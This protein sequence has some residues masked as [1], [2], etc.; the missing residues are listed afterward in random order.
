MN[1]LYICIFVLLEVYLQSRVL[2]VGL[3]GQKVGVYA[4]LLGIAKF[5]FR[6]VDQ[7]SFPL[8]VCKSASFSP[9][10]RSRMCPHACLLFL[11]I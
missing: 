6:A 8:A 10:P 1:T 11:P 2:E 9:Q 7:F 5:S 4:V 3:L